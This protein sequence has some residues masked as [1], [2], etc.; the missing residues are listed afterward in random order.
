M[1]I[2][3]K[4]S[5]PKQELIRIVKTDTGFVIDRKGKMNGRGS[6]ICNSDD[7]MN[8]LV[9]NKVLNKV[10]KTNVSIDMYEE[11]KEQ[12]FENREG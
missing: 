7:C 3:C 5:K 10:F 11:L 12:F 1:C 2:T 6:Y 4:A 9:K 8:K